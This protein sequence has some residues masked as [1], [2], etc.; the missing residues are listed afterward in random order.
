MFFTAS[1]R[2][3]KGGILNITCLEG[4]LKRVTT[5]F[6]YFHKLH[7]QNHKNPTFV[8]LRPGKVG[9]CILVGA[10]STAGARLKKAL[11]RK[12]LGRHLGT[13]TSKA[14]AEM[15]ASSWKIASILVM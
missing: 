14:S 10:V 5:L 3:D 12:N 8:G 6:F 1:A 9:L 11:Q 15:E 4:D 2:G 13:Q 7:L